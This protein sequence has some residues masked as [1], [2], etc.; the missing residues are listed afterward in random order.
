LSSPRSLLRTPA[1]MKRQHVDCVTASPL[2]GCGVVIYRKCPLIIPG[3]RYRQTGFVVSF[4][5]FLPQHFWRENQATITRPAYFR[6]IRRAPCVS[7]LSRAKRHPCTQAV[8]SYAPYRLS[9]I[10]TRP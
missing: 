6:G 2:P 4:S 3:R 9:F 1:A 8:G 5:P 7:G 10:Y